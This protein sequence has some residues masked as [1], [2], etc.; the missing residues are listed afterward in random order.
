MP[1]GR[2][3]PFY[4]QTRH[5]QVGAAKTGKLSFKRAINTVGEAIYKIQKMIFYT[6]WRVKSITGIPGT[7]HLGFINGVLL[8]PSLTSK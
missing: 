1:G 8:Y 3:T 6:N 2:L 5:G 4:G 7:A